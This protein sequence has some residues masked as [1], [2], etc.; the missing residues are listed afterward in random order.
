MPSPHEASRISRREFLNLSFA[1]GGLVLA[2]WFGQWAFSVPGPI[3]EERRPFASPGWL[4]TRNPDRPAFISADSGG[5]REYVH[6]MTTH[7]PLL[8]KVCSRVFHD[9]EYETYRP[10]LKESFT[11]HVLYAADEM[12]DKDPSISDIVHV[13]FF[14]FA[15]VYS[16]FYTYG[17]V[18]HDFNVRDDHSDYDDRR[19][20]SIYDYKNNVP[21]VFK[22]SQPIDIDKVMHF[23]NFAFVAHQFEYATLYGLQESSRVPRLAH[24][25]ASVGY[26]PEKQ[27]EIMVFLGGLAWES[28]ETGVWVNNMIKNNKFLVPVGGYFDSGFWTDFQANIIGFRFAAELTGK[29]LTPQSLRGAIAKLEYPELLLGQT[30]Q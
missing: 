26:S 8:R 5:H 9:L 17:D 15:A 2:D 6:Y 24:T 19:D 25:L 12:K 14:T 23:A 21:L 18:R 13:A 3:D 28:Y 10:T 16:N 7:D 27:A 29:R 20:F 30:E 11:R 4:E 22:N 1:S